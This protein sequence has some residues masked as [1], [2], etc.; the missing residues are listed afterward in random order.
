MQPMAPVAA[1]A[2]Q[3]NSLRGRWGSSTAM[4]HLVEESRRLQREKAA[5]AREAGR[6]GEAEQKEMET[7]AR[8]GTEVVKQEQSQ[9]GRMREGVPPAADSGKRC[10]TAAAT[11]STAP[12]LPAPRAA[13]E[14]AKGEEGGNDRRSAAKTPQ[15]RT[16]C[17]PRWSLKDPQ[18]PN[19]DP[20][21]FSVGRHRARLGLDV[22]SNGGSDAREPTPDP[23]DQTTVSRPAPKILAERKIQR[24]S[25]HATSASNAS[26]TSSTGC[27]SQALRELEC[28]SRTTT[29][30]APPQI[31]LSHPK[32]LAVGVLG[33]LVRVE[34]KGNDCTHLQ[35]TETPIATVAALV[36]YERGGKVGLQGHQKYVVT[37][38][39]CG[40]FS[41]RLNEARSPSPRRSI[42]QWLFTQPSAQTS[43]RMLPLS[44]PPAQPHGSFTGSLRKTIE[45]IFEAAAM[46]E[47]QIPPASRDFLRVIDELPEEVRTKVIT[48]FL[49]YQAQ[50]QQLSAMGETIDPLSSAVTKAL[51]K[52]VGTHCLRSPAPSSSSPSQLSV[53]TPPNSTAEQQATERGN[54]HQPPPLLPLTTQPAVARSEPLGS[55][56][57]QTDRRRAAS[58]QPRPPS[59]RRLTT[60]E[61][62]LPKAH[63]LTPSRPAGSPKRK[64][65]PPTAKVAASSRPKTKSHSGSRRHVSPTEEKPQKSPPR[66]HRP[67]SASC[68]AHS[69][70]QDV[71]EK[72]RERSRS[73]SAPGKS[74]P[75]KAAANAA[76]EP[77]AEPLVLPLIQVTDNGKRRNKRES[78]PRCCSVAPTAEKARQDFVEEQRRQLERHNQQAQRE[79]MKAASAA[80][81][82]TT[83]AARLANEHPARRPT[84][85]AAAA[86][87]PER[88]QH[89][90]AASQCF[91][92]ALST[93]AAP[94][95]DTLVVTDTTT[96]IATT[97]PLTA[98]TRAAA[99]PVSA[100]TPEVSFTRPP[101]RN[102]S[103]PPSLH[104]YLKSIESEKH[105]ALPSV[106]RLMAQFESSQRLPPSPGDTFE[107]AMF[108][109]R[110]SRATSLQ[111]LLRLRPTVEPKARDS[112]D[113]EVDDLLRRYHDNH[114]T[115]DGDEYDL[116]P[117]A[118]PVHFSSRTPTISPAE[119]QVRI[120]PTLISSYSSP[121]SGYYYASPVESQA[122]SSQSQLAT[123]GSGETSLNSQYSSS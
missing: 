120:S 111:R 115:N 58:P 33:R 123:E 109:H 114:D 15:R 59:T 34:L 43:A 68:T 9:Q 76:C 110:C 100:A 1:A 20:L 44:T 107:R 38:R 60:F 31:S 39:R 83:R 45:W 12:E 113:D 89:L 108:L 13:P 118:L 63:P 54:R 101:N 70:K 64:K 57:A 53:S 62:V 96:T 69:D 46:I 106:R 51:R 66:N 5:K 32:S 56:H 30:I 23:F 49:L 95:Q 117:M 74:K 4:K 75:T 81:A 27:N 24:V 121:F 61:R 16:A 14:D 25:R 78:T 21:A 55:S 112:I 92:G 99:P 18:D 86:R 103:L 8:Q 85:D 72:K 102:N 77:V 94:V 41:P 47:V 36:A 73:R 28:V 79:M 17:S 98:D 50:V 80:A 116:L 105:M 6:H 19:K 22:V 82:D 42:S 11:S 119:S 84:K 52:W 29:D 87:E 35:Q 71:A 104:G 10:G 88:A 91:H 97:S 90:L 67:L 7:E 37:Q 65:T 93:I 40:A 26:D 48:I 3:I 2:G 122:A